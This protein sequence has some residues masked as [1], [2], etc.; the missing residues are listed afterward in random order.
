M[1]KVGILGSTGSIGTQSLEVIN[2]NKEAY[3]VTLL[4]CFSQVSL[5][6]QQIMAFRPE[7]VVLGGEKE[8]EALLSL[9]EAEGY[10]HP[11]TI[12]VGYLGLVEAVKQD[13]CDF[14][15]NALVGMIGL[16]PTYEAIKAG[17]QIGLANKET[18][19]AGGH[20]ITT[21]ATEKKVDILP[22]DSE[23][24][25][26]FQCLQGNDSREVERL[27]LTAS[28]GP[29]RGYDLEG[30]S[31]VTLEQA[32]KHPNWSMGK[33][34]TI[35]S[36]TLMNKGLEV[37][38]A[39]WLFKKPWDRIDVVIH[40]QSIIHSMVEYVDH[41][42][43]AQLGTPNMKVPIAYSLSYPHRLKSPDK[44]LDFTKLK[45][46]DFEMPDLDT[47]VCLKLAYTALKMGGTYAL[48]LN[49]ANEVLVDLFLREK[50][51]YLDIQKNLEILLDHHV[52]HCVSD[53]KINL[54]TLI[55]I[56]KETRRKVMEL[57]Y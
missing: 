30:L 20:L 33:K 45:T 57:C 27:I 52:N 31:K 13:N 36:S 1:K 22:I 3:R 48:A 2:E 17:K 40:P 23:H 8:Q 44:G 47:F 46:L 4:T 24:S 14:L 19:V 5:L 53:Q 55:E 34:I 50:I 42:V 28:G 26:I 6:A 7:T 37:I 16:E 25:A 38:E 21:L 49:A 41:S 54:E 15:I 43:M 18:L 51:A 10:Q 11:L 29:F 39:H 32:L 35:D 12:K 9:L 56:D